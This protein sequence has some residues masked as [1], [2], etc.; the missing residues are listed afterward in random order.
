MSK[1][2]TILFDV[3]G[4]L[5]EFILAFTALANRLYGTPIIR[6]EEQPSW[7]FSKLDYIQ[8][9]RV[10]EIIQ[11]TPG[12]WTGLAPLVG[13]ETLGR[14]HRL[15]RTDNVVF[16]TSRVSDVDPAARQTVEWLRQLGIPNPSVVVTKLKGDLARL[17]QADYAIDDKAENAA[18]IHWIS[19]SPQTQV[20][21]LDRPYNRNYTLPD[22]IKRIH[23]VDQFLMDIE[24]ER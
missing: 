15:T 11:A 1:L 13:P 10:W 23:T 12:W 14:I 16:G 17:I 24:E 5:A 2:K 18:C 22:R 3:D 6:T 19:D 9:R 21:L 20:Y 4:V 7:R 8:E